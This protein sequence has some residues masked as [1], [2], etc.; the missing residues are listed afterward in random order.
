M[1]TLAADLA[2][3]VRT[4]LAESHIRALSRI[5]EE[6]T[7]AAGEMVEHRLFSLAFDTV[8]A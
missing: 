4:P 5:A 6:V 3:M 8:A 2:T 1:E 7:F